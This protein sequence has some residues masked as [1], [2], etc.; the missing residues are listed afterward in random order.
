MG[1]FWWE[2][3]DLKSRKVYFPA[4]RVNKNKEIWDF[5]G[6][7]GGKVGII[8]MP[9]TYPPKKVNGFMIA[10]GSFAKEY[11][12]TYPQELESMLRK[13]FDYKVH[14]KEYFLIKREPERVVKEVFK[15]IESRFKVARKLL[16]EHDLDFLHV[17]TFYIN[18]LH[19]NFWNNKYVEDAWRLIDK[20]IDFLLEGLEDR[21]NVFIISDHGSNKIEQVF[22]INNWLAKEGY[23]KLS[24]KVKFSYLLYALGV[25]QQ[26]L[27]RVFSKPFLKAFKPL[28]RSLVPARITGLFAS[29]AGTIDQSRKTD[30]VVWDK[31]KAIAS[32]QGPVY[33]NLKGKEKEKVREELIKKLENVR[34]PKTG[35]KIAQKVYRKEEIYSGEYLSEAPDLIIDQTLGTHIRGGIGVGKRDV[36][37]DPRGWKAENK[38]EGIFIAYGPDI[39]KGERLKKIS[40]LDLAPT[41]LHLMGIPIPDDMDGRVL[42]EIFEPNSE[43]AKRKI[44]YQEVKAHR[45]QREKERIKQTVKKIREAGGLK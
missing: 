17:T 14:P 31:T 29:E 25:N 32:G 42:T 28:L 34:N 9:L 27:N 8:N 26:S 39:K 36:F 22:Y 43:P 24:S 6:E 20:N 4:D 10:G 12:F 15:I 3:I 40:I 18:T 41:I 21:Y 44:K 38:R 16:I 13:E 35:K 1:I 33:I 30:K 45:T 5:V 11:N 19:H 7:N 23:L 2:N 37:E